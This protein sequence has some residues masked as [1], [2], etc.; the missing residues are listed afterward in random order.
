MTTLLKSTSIKRYLPVLLCCLS[1]AACGGG[2]SGAVGAAGAVPTVPAAPISVPTPTPLPG[3]QTLPVPVNSAPTASAVTIT[4]SNGGSVVVG[5]TLVGSYTYADADG[6]AQGVS[7]FRWLRNGVAISGA[8]AANYTLVT[9]D[10]GTSITFEVT[11][12]AATG[13]TV[14]AAAS[15][16]SVSVVNSAP[17]ASA[18][19]ITDSNGG[20]V[21]VGDTLVG[22]YTY[23]DANGDV[24]GVSTFRWLRNGVAISGAVAA[25]YSVVAADVGATISFEVTPVAATGIPTGLA[26]VS[27]A[28]VVVLANSPPIANAV[29][30]NG[31]VTVGSV[32]TG[33]YTYSDID[34]DAQGVSTFRWLRDGV[35]IAGATSST[36][37][38]T[39]ADIKA[40]VGAAPA[41]GTS[42]SFEVT[43]VAATGAL[44]GVPVSYAVITKAKALHPIGTNLAWIR[45]WSNEIVF[46]D[47]FKRAR[48]WVSVT[49]N[50][51][52][53]NSSPITLDSNGWVTKLAPNQMAVSYIFAYNKN[54][55]H[56]PKGTYRCSYAGSGIIQITDATVLASGPGWMDIKFNRSQGNYG[57]V[58]VRIKQTDPLNYIKDIKIQPL[59]AD[60]TV[61][62]ATFRADFL[63][64]W[65]PFK[66]LRFMD[67]MDTNHVVN[68]KPQFA[69]AI[70]WS[71]RP[72]V[73]DF[74]QATKNGVAL[75][76][77]IELCNTLKINPW[78]NMPATATDAY[79][80][81]FATMVKNK[82]DP[83]LKAYV[84]YSNEVW[85]WGFP[86]SHYA[87]AMGKKLGFSSPWINFYTHRALQILGI[88]KSV[89]G[90]SSTTRLVRVL[91]GQSAYVWL[92]TH[93]LDFELAYTK[94]DAFAIAPYFGWD[95]KK[96]KLSATSPISAFF[97]AIDAHLIALN[98]LFQQYAL[99]TKTRNVKLIAYEGGQGMSFPGGAAL[100]SMITKINRDPYIYTLYTRYLTN[101]S[102]A[103]GGLFMNFSSVIAPSKWG[104]WGVLEW[105]DLPV[106]P[107]SKYAAIKDALYRP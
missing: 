2:G 26:A 34:G 15:S 37:T 6:D 19:T 46:N 28:G 10:T 9:A 13:V 103:G 94:I 86:A 51:G 48:A 74:S 53:S 75:E 22:S 38:L 12:V 39:P 33:L 78:F 104:N 1:L 41:V 32:L 49:I 52:G 30:I 29:H 101:W 45:D 96:F 77:M 72:K 76:Y 11:P 69:T 65:R 106:I 63:N 25:N 47:V 97:T 85:N 43:P 87:D 73:T 18:V 91:S 3:P 84:E 68:Y 7:T 105:Y 36:Y 14:G 62:T 60:G 59:K 57:I 31:T 66:V 98:A 23:A 89:F 93:I 42:I 35:P 95:R 88:W 17:T 58:T 102:L 82:L 27:P 24:E 64:R 67:W 54:G 20:S 56:L 99:I 5:D 100:T 83:S 79:I 90:A 107:T 71:D 21:V 8:V 16:A 92:S 50:N 44:K 61:N 55:Q 81:Q 80:T 4:D 70:N 40:T